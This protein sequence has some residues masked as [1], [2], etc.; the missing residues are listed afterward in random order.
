[1]RVVSIKIHN[2]RTFADVELHLTPYS[3]L[4]GTNNAGKSNLIDAIR[5][6]YEKDISYDESR[7]FPKFATSDTE[8]WIEI[9]YKPT[10]EEFATL[11]DDYQ[12][13]DGTFRVRKYLQSTEA[14]S[15]GKTKTGI[16][17]YVGGNLSN[18][19]FYGAK[20]IQQGKLGEI[21]YIPAVSKLDDHTKLTGPSALRDLVNA[22]LKKIMGSSV[23][24][25]KLKA[26]F[27]EFETVIKTETTEDGQSLQR[28]EADITD[29]INGWGTSFKF[30]VNPISPDELIKSLIGHGVQDHALDKIQDTKSYGQGF[31]RHLIFTLI[32][33]SARYKNPPVATKDFS[34]RMTWILF[35]EPEAFLHPGQIDV[36]DESLDKIIMDEGN[37]VLITTHSPRFVSRNIADLPALIRLCKTTA[38]TSAKQIS[39]EILDS[40]LNTNQHDLS[41][42]K[43]AGIPIHPDDLQMDMESVKYALWLNPHRCS[44]FFANKILLVEGATESALIGYMFEEGLIHNP[45]GGVF[46]FDSIGK[47]NI[48]RFMN[49]FGELGI[50]HAVLYDHDNGKTTGGLVE[51]TINSSIN[52]FTLGIDCF[53]Q[54]L[55][56]FLGI[57]PAGRADRKPQHVMY[58]LKQGKIA[59]DKLKG[60]ASKVQTL[61]KL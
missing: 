33:L 50:P 28:L 57:P 23:A 6:F 49:L 36:L 27:D 11:K 14:D 51:S 10:A 19:R 29:E 9:Q 21:I 30:S 15:E 26:A 55:E 59:E 44:A 58:H 5:V 31:Q 41:A 16:Y 17:A 47:Y 46:I 24:Y 7:D 1:M 39:R 20:N 34:P 54:D 37:Q 18:A 52:G 40:I 60:L 32:R 2:F 38:E 42:W 22:V 4:L 13:S 45:T 56:A 35:E 61:L 3:L 43:A 8:V 48:H 25:T 53:G 12:L